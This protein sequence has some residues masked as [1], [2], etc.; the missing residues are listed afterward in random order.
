MN[1]T[2]LLNYVELAEGK[3]AKTG[4]VRHWGDGYDY[5]KQGDGTWKK[6][7]KSGSAQP[8][9]P[10]TADPL[11]TT[12]AA[13]I[14]KAKELR[15]AP[16]ADPFP[17]AQW[18]Q[19]STDAGGHHERSE[20]GGFRL[21]VSQ[22]WK[23]TDWSAEVTDPK[24][25][26]VAKQGGFKSMADAQM[27]AKQAVAA[28]Q[29]AQAAAAPPP[30]QSSGKAASDVKSALANRKTK[31]GG[32]LELDK[33]GSDENFISFE[34]QYRQRLDHYGT[35]Y[36]SDDE[37]QEGWDEEG[38]EQDY[39]GPLRDEVEA[40]LKDAGFDL[41]QWVVDV[42]EK[43]HVEVQRVRKANEGIMNVEALLDE[44][45]S[46]LENATLK[47]A[48]DPVGYN[49]ALAKLVG[50]LKKNKATG[51][52]AVRQGYKGT[53]S[54][55][56]A[57]QIWL[58]VPDHERGGPDLWLENGYAKIGGIISMPNTIPAVRK[59]GED[60]PEVVYNW[61]VDTMQQFKA[62]LDAKY[63]QPPKSPQES[64]MNSQMNQKLE[65]LRATLENSLGEEGLPKLPA[66]PKGGRRS[67]ETIPTAKLSSG[68]TPKPPAPA[69]NA[70]GSQDL[71]TQGAQSKPPSKK[72]ADSVLPS[73]MEALPGFRR[74]SGLEDLRRIVTPEE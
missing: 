3:R 32:R 55:A 58:K 25:K 20:V 60:A 73:K 19:F 65:A 36:D 2:R 51:V 64:L 35:S 44:T 61:I 54:K 57:R 43:G 40:M 66:P 37:E 56:Y 17:H 22:K 72:V 33:E 31:T 24:W 68:S 67:A 45:R 62:F 50:G 70:M 42:G 27:F 23:E 74:L 10:S 52:S 8:V 26:T 53:G 13:S 30:P 71:K 29:A 39:A 49:T 41:N 1:P 4:E 18:T 34:P 63:A 5:E 11:A 59:Y 69:K 21:R 12:V 38:W 14:A 15:A 7:A 6:L 9:K 48:D 16:A 46:L 47:F 28:A